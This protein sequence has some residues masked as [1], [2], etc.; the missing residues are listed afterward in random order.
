MKKRQEIS[1]QERICWYCCC[2]WWL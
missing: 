2:V 1:I